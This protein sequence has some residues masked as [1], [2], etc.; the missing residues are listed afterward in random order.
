[1]AIKLSNRDLQNIDQQIVKDNSFK[2]RVKQIVEGEFNRIHVDFLKA[3]EG[4]PVTQEIR[5]G[6]SAANISRTLGGV[7]NLF[8]YIGFNLG[9]DPIKSLR[10]LLE[11][12]EI[13]YHPRNKYMSIQ[14]EVPTKE[15]V[16][17]ATPMPWATGR[18]W[19]RGIERGISGLGKYLVKS[20]RIAKSKSGFAIQTDTRVRG[21]RF[22]NTSYIS[23]LLNNYYKEIQKLEKKTF[24]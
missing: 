5:G 7:G 9:S 4:H 21:G 16:F 24:S 22:S 8:T 10:K 15:Q 18:S 23:A 12:Y 2:K 14:I 17:I 11:A 3:F 6:P 20:S 1:M 13:H 19:A